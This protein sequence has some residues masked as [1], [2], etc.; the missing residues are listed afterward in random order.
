[1]K[2]TVAIYHLKIHKEDRNEKTYPT[3]KVAAVQAAPVFLD[4]EKTVEKTCRI[5][6]ETVSN[7]QS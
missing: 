7:G 4:L 2:V 1:M 6:D 3:Y 5:I